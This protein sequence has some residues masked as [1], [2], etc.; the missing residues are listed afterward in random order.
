MWTP[1]P[2]LAH[3]LGPDATATP[4]Q[5]LE[6]AQ[7][8]DAQDPLASM[9]AEFVIPAYPGAAGKAVVVGAT[10]TPEQAIYLLG[11]SLGLMPKAAEALV[12]QELSVWGSW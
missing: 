5:W 2:E 12:H 1:P 6:L 7:A 10:T 11:N 4:E 9:R 3:L 8:L